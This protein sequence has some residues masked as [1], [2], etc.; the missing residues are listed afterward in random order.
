MKIINKIDWYIG[1]CCETTGSGRAAREPGIHS[2]GSDVEF[3]SP[4]KSG[5][6]DRILHPRRP[7]ALGVRVHAK[8]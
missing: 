2:G 8:W 7:E 1:C 6:L 5:Q 3:A 4:Q